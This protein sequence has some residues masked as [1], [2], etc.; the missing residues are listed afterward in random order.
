MLLNVSKHFYLEQ[1]AEASSSA[2]GGSVQAVENH[3]S[4]A[5]SSNDSL[6]QHPSP[7]R[8]SLRD[9]LHQHGAWEKKG[10]LIN[11]MGIESVDDLRC[12]FTSACEADAHGLRTQ[13]L[14]VHQSGA[15]SMQGQVHGASP[16][17]SKAGV[18]FEGEAP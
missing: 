16:G 17:D 3:G 2:D 18:H 5:R 8:R 7:G 6:Q 14:L 4:P 11:E 15:Q 10:N 9:I 1:M 13:W 12:M